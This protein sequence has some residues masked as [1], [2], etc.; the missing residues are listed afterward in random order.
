LVASE[1]IAE[2]SAGRIEA[3]HSSEQIVARGEIQDVVKRAI[4]ELLEG[5]WRPHEEDSF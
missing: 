4:D 2:S 5:R 3:R 1:G